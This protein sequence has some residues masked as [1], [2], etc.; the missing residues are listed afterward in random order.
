MVGTNM[1]LGHRIRHE[2]RA[3]LGSHFDCRIGLEVDRSLDK[4][5]EITVVSPVRLNLLILYEF[6][7]KIFAENFD[8]GPRTRLTISPVRMQTATSF[9]VKSI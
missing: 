5:W 7:H 8:V 9:I 2:P 3:N 6:V 4:L 1:S